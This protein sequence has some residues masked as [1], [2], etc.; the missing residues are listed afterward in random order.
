[1]HR[2]GYH[3]SAY[4][5][6]CPALLHKSTSNRS[7][8]NMLSTSVID[9]YEQRSFKIPIKLDHWLFQNGCQIAASTVAGLTDILIQA[10]LTTNIG[11]M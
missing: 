8:Y 5:M 2:K 6:F 3:K 11:L 7:S 4:H 9:I 1:M 10:L